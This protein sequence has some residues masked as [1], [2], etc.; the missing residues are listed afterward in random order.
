MAEKA[1]PVQDKIEDLKGEFSPKPE[2][3]VDL[4]GLEPD[5]EIQ[6]NLEQWGNEVTNPDPNS[7]Y[8]WVNPWGSGRFII[9]KQSQGWRLVSNSRNDKECPHLVDSNGYRRNGDVLLMKVSKERFAELQKKDE[10][11]RARQQQG[12]TSELEEAGAKSRYLT[13]HVGANALSRIPGMKKL[14]A[15]Q[16]ASKQFDGLLR[17]GKIPGVQIP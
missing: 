5:R 10:A 3:T 14:L 9:R 8:C 13:V 4:K 7:E 12:I 15:R 1:N 6:G 2:M 17:D 11:R 16:I